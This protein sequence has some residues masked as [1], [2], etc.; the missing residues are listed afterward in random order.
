MER[1]HEN[2]LGLLRHN[3]NSNATCRGNNFNGLRSMD[4]QV[5]K[6]FKLQGCR[7]WALLPIVVQK[8]WRKYTIEYVINQGRTG[9]FHNHLEVGRE[10]LEPITA[11][12]KNFIGG[13]AGARGF[14][15]I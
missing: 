9:F 12:A 3:C 7:L 13:Q 10:L 1:D 4:Y 14:I 8:K 6:D 2:I 11:R 5:N 15:I